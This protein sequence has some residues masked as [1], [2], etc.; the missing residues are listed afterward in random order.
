MPGPFT[1]SEATLVANTEGR[2]SIRL[3]EV[4]WSAQGE[5]LNIGKPSIFIRLSGCSVQCDY[6]DQKEAWQDG[7]LLELPVLLQKV[8]ALKHRYPS[9][10]TV[11]T[12][13]EPLEQDILVLVQE[14]RRQALFIAIE[15]S[16]GFFQQLPLDWWSVAPKPNLDYRIHP[17]LV[18][19]IDEIKLVVSPQLTVQTVK[20]IRRSIPSAPIFLQPQFFDPG[21][22]QRSYQL[23]KECQQQAIPDVRLGLQLHTVY[24]IQ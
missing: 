14:L 11:I 22:F 7:E 6:C 12:G 17:S 8:A 13:G 5:G 20:E 4:F 18:E 24:K 23:Y 16:G 1:R 15:T 10:M 9:S 3:S 2:G 21:K 19:K